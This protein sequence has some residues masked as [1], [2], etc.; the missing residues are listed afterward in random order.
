[1]ISKKLKSG[2]MSR[3]QGQ[4]SRDIVLVA[5]TH[6]ARGNH[7]R[8]LN[9]ITFSRRRE[10]GKDFSIQGR[11]IAAL[12]RRTNKAPKMK[13]EISMQE[14]IDSES[15]GMQNQAFS[16]GSR[17]SDGGS[18]DVEDGSFMVDN[19]R[20]SPRKHGPGYLDEVSTEAFFHRI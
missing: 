1:M 6:I 2:Q 9:R 14:L 8:R 11:S 12:T 20:L 10:N 7:A 17:D 16:Q 3:E 19:R 18:N 15:R 5:T 4:V 13:H